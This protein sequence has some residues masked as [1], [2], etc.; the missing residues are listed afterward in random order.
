MKNAEMDRGNSKDKVESTQRSHNLSLNHMQS[1]YCKYKL[2]KA[3]ITSF[4]ND[5]SRSIL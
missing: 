4:A 1:C 5:A 2:S 3:A